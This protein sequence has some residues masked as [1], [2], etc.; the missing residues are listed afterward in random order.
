MT[1]QSLIS[2]LEMDDSIDCQPS[3]ILVLPKTIRPDYSQTRRRTITSDTLNEPETQTNVNDEQ[4][5]PPM[6]W[7]NIPETNNE[8]EREEFI[9]YIQRNA[10]LTFAGLIKRRI[11]S[12]TYLKE[13]VIRSLHR[14]YP[15]YCF[16][17]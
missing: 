16:L 1:F 6:T 8:L 10:R 17:S 11:L 5:D 4:F 7:E 12:D 13:L 9:L 15:Y 14:I 2:D 3:D